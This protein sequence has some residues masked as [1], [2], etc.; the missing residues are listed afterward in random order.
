MA[1]KGSYSLLVECLLT[2]L[3]DHYHPSQQW[4]DSRVP[5][6]WLVKSFCLACSIVSMLNRCSSPSTRTFQAI[7]SPFFFLFSAEDNSSHLNCSD[8]KIRFCCYVSFHVSATTGIRM[9]VGYKKLINCFFFALGGHFLPLPAWRPPSPHGR[10]ARQWRSL[11]RPL[12]KMLALCPTR[13]VT[14]AGVFNL[15]WPKGQI[16]TVERLDG[17]KHILHE[18][19][20][21]C[22]YYT[23]N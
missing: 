6:E 4:T 18:C 2:S 8:Y 5:S 10:R 11:W 16:L 3:T 14:R 19:M 15:L 7:L 1:L 13:C 12:M 23:C 22:V 21:I 17:R 9:W 20:C